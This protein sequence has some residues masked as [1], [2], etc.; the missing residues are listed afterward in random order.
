MA[1]DKKKILILGA[2]GMLGS[3]LVKVFAKDKPVAWGKKDLDITKQREVEKKIAQHKPDILI[4]AAA[5]TAV[6]ECEK[7][8][9]KA[10][11]V[12]GEAVGYLAIACRKID[13]L[14]VQYSTDYIFGG[15][16]PKGYNENDKPHP[17]NTY[18]KSKL[19]GEKMLKKYGK[20]YY[21]IR[22]SWLYGKNGRNFVD[23]ICEMSPKRFEIKVVNDQFGKPTYARDL[24]NRTKEIIDKKL[25]FG[26][27]HL[28]NEGVTTWYKLAKEVCRIKRFKTRILPI[29]SFEI[30][31]PAKR[32]TY[33]I[34][35][36]TKIKKSR[37][38]HKALIEYLKTNG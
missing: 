5:F 15:R 19:Y 21:I 12:N 36:N 32:P 25:A 24:A 29:T 8:A 33:S 9:D 35:I 30:P 14:L 20:D 4:N 17:I 22:T 7:K 10:L 3:E 18:G 34:L 38:W 16:K 28:T 26:I 6:D 37:N 31:R 2:N 11:S 13:C 1:K 27:Y 23:A